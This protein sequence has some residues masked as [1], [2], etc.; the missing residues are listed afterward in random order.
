[1]EIVQKF[2]VGVSEI[3]ITMSPYGATLFERKFKEYSGLH[4]RSNL[5]ISKDKEVRKTS[6]ERRYFSYIGTV[7]KGKGIYE[8]IALINYSLK[9]NDDLEFCLITSSN[10]NEY[11][12]L[13]GE[14]Y[15]SKLTIINKENISDFEISEVISRSLAVFSIHNVAAQSGVLPLAYS[16]ST[17]TIIRDIPAFNQYKIDDNLILP[18]DFSEIQ[19]YNVCNSILRNKDNFAQYEVKCKAAYD[20]YF[21]VTNFELFY[22]QLINKL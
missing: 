5:L 20:K 4:I 22:S 2:S 1:V 6:L 13:L 18:V 10:I 9:M 19:I 15:A 7:N 16:L 17:P 3:V 12:P 14:N 8:F 21:S 11:L